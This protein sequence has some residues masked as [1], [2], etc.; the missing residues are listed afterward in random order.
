MFETSGGSVESATIR[1]S[2][3]QAAKAGA[4]FLF[5][6]AAMA[7]LLTPVYALLYMVFVATLLRALAA[8]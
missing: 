7:A 2:F 5:G 3:W 1:V 8:R 6:A 4:G